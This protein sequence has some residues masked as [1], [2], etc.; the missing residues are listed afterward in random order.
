MLKCPKVLAL[1]CCLLWLTPALSVAKAIPKTYQP[2]ASASAMLVDMKSGEVLY[3]EH[4]DV[5]RPIASVSKLLTVLVVLDAKQPL[6]ERIDVNVS[7]VPSM[8]NVVSRLRIGSTL[9]RKE[10]IALA[11]MSSENRA[12][13]TLAHHYPG[14]FPA[15][16][17]AM[18]N[19]AKTL[20]MR[21]SHF[22]EPTGLSRLNVSSASDLVKLLKAT[23]TYPIMGQLS[24]AKNRS[25][26][27]HKPSYSLAFYNTNPLVNKKGWK[28]HLTKTGYTDEAGH[29]LV[30]LT[31]MAGRQVAFVVL[32]AFG[33]Y[34]HIADANRL[35][36]WL[37][38]GKVSKVPADALAYKQEAQQQQQ[39]AKNQEPSDG[40]ETTAQH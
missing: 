28:I 24:S 40:V 26:T 27:F 20:G 39:T 12:A 22:V 33:K 29:C 1:L 2:L 3:A 7:D 31:E 36:T 15:F 17:K 10:A 18:N 13:A 23:Q 11:L 32:D 21:H 30:M 37:S 19:K 5:A 38:T 9:L 6:N 8:D 34:T 16:I 35:K 25:V 14:G 4:E